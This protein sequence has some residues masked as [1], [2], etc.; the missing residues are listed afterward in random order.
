MTALGPLCRQ[1]R[2]SAHIGDIHALGHQKTFGDSFACWALR[3]NRASRKKTV[4]RSATGRSIIPKDASAR[5]TQ[6]E[7]SEALGILPQVIVGISVCIFSR[8]ADNEPSRCNPLLQ[9]RALALIQFGILL[10]R[11]S[12]LDVPPTSCPHNF[13]RLNLA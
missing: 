9:R 12:L 4:S 13:A 11:N 5:L 10:A 7:F 3:A 1:L 8:V 2:T 6:G